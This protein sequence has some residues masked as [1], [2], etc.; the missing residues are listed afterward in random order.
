MT[1]PRTVD[2]V[3]VI[4]VVVHCHPGCKHGR[5]L[6]K[7]GCNLSGIVRRIKK[8]LRSLLLT[9]LCVIVDK[10]P[11]LIDHNK[12]EAIIGQLFRH[13]IPAVTL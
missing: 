5:A 12:A 1:V 3:D 7:V 9:V 8:S 6:H 2:R 4:K 10:I 11:V 13:A